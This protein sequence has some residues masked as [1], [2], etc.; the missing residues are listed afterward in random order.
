[1]GSPGRV[2]PRLGVTLRSVGTAFDPGKW[3]AFATGLAGATAALTGLVFV[4]VSIHL[5]AILADPFH[6]RRAQSTFLSLLVVLGAALVLLIPNIGRHIY[7][8]LCILVAAPLSNR[9]ARSV[10]VLK[11]REA[12]REQWMTWAA[13]ALADLLLVV[14]GVGLLIQGIGGL[15]VVAAGLLLMAA[16][17]MTVVWIL[18][19][20]L[21]EEK[22]N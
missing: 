4:S 3:Q 8:A 5:E 17:A 12:D 20:T 9:A 18:F 13:A 21:S 11:S 1:M 14:G 6:R 19:L 16:R 22:A 15:Y 7:G 10:A 2:G